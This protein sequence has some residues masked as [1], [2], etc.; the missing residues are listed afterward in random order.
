MKIIKSIHEYHETKPLKSWIF[1]IS[2]RTAIDYNRKKKPV[3]NTDEL[4]HMSSADK[5]D[6]LLENNEQSSQM[7]KLLSHLTDEDAHLLKL[8]YLNEKSIKDLVEITH[9]S[10]SNLKIKLYRI[11]KELAKYVNLYF[12]KY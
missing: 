12:E 11:R 6:T 10:E 3:V 7:E 1:A 8:Y 2:Y 4:M 9:L 5:T